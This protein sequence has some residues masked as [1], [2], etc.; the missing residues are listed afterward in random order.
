M[1]CPRLCPAE[2]DAVLQAKSALEQ[3]PCHI[4]VVK[5]QHSCQRDNVCMH[6]RLV[7]EQ[8]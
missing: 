2:Y 3:S 4:P 7:T 8:R 1:L 6:A 5:Q